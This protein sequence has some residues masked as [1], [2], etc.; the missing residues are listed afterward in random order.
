MTDTAP[1]A[2]VRAVTHRYGKVTALKDVTLDLAAGQMLGLIGPDGVGKSTLL[3]L[4]AGARK[5]QSGEVKVLGG[6]MAERGHREGAFHRIA[7]M[8]Q[9]LGKNLYMELS[10]RENLDFFARLF[11]HDA[12]ERQRRIERLLKATGLDPFPDRPAGKLSGGMKQKLGLCCSLIHDPDFLILD[13]PTTGVD[14]LSRGQFWDLIDDIRADR[15][16]M[17]VLVST[18]YMEEADR[19]DSLV[20]MDAGQVL[21]T[22]TPEELRQQTGKDDL[23]AAFV[24][25]LPRDKQREG[26]PLVIPPRETREG[27]PAIIARGL[28]RRFGD[29]TA[30][31]DV[32][33][34]IERGEIF[35]FLGSNGCGKTTTMKMLTGL[36]PPSEGQALIFG[37][38]VDANDVA[39]RNNV[40]FMSQNF[41]LYGELTVA[42]NFRL[43]ARLYHLP[44][45][46]ARA[47]MKELFHDFDLSEY[48]DSLARSLP[49][50][51]RQRLSLACAVIHSPAMLILDEPTSGVDPVARDEFWVLLARLSRRDGVTIF[52]STHFMNEA[53]RC[54][55]I[56]LMHAGEVLVYDTPQ[57]LA[58]E[59]GA[60][61]LEETFIRYIGGAIG[62]ADQPSGAARAAIHDIATKAPSGRKRNPAIGRLLAVSRREMLEVMRDPIRLAFAFLGS[63][64]L[65][66]LF[67][68]GI[69]TDTTGLKF[70]AFDQDKTPES[71]AY[72]ANFEGSTY[73][74]EMPEVSSLAELEQRMVAGEIGLAIEIPAGFGRAVTTGQPTSV[75]AW[76]DGAITFRASMTEGYVQGAHSAFLSERARAEG[77]G[78]TAQPIVN[79]EPRYRYNPTYESLVSMAPSVPAI[80]LM[81]FPA[82]LMAVSVSREREIGTI[83]NFYV[84]PTSKLQF[85]L[86]KQ[87]PYVGIGFANWLILT[88][89][90]VF[91]FG[92]PLKGSALALAFGAV[93]YVMA[94]TGFGLVIATMV[95]SQVSAVFATMILAM[96]PTVQFSGLNQ[97]VSSLEGVAR[98]MGQLWPTNYFMQMSIGA[99]NKSLG[100]V[101]MAPNIF[102]VFAFVPVFVGIAAL[103]LKKQEA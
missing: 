90:A 61:S 25:L 85:L 33:F 8:P 14:P 103:L 46:V 81:L 100:F 40:G 36:L 59:N 92:V 102:L 63:M 5:I 2:S 66:L 3:G 23:E 4:L 32:T 13:E 56:S 7:Y 83:T 10:V 86:G 21:A 16:G 12:A 95:K 78:G 51:L 84:T 41:S 1:I 73:F 96:M 35:G 67:A 6:S 37:E 98:I 52:I 58:R 69:S 94:A 31:H 76:I 91:L 60:T 65:M 93:T 74:D 34:E 97:P 89:M 79:I 101:Q 30:V 47:R 54:D 70:A 15:P 20:A 22:G 44:P 77:M 99:F 24:S 39:A 38:P 9:G 55:R 18:A 19:F 72:L 45:D 26:G 88:G 62:A 87:L 71:R 64:I 42:E 75:A 27:G 48:G 50:G 68:Y 11:G 29:F 57:N 28:T 17:S 53:M 82:I 49:L 80:L 43:H